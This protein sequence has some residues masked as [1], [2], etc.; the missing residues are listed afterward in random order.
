MT[1]DS[2]VEGQW[3]ENPLKRSFWSKRKDLKKEFLTGGRTNVKTNSL[4]ILSLSVDTG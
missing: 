4:R 3:D 2:P 1:Y